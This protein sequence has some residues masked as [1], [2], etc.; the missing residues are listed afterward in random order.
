M[1]T[2]VERAQM[3]A[4]IQSLEAACELAKATLL[5]LQSVELAKEHAKW[6]QDAVTVLRAALPVKR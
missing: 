2:I 3:R 1:Q 6:V 4:R 5:A